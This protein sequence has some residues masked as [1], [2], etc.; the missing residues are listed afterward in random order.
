MGEHSKTDMLRIRVTEDERATLDGAAAAAGQPTGTWIRETALTA[1]AEQ[2]A[3]P[4]KK[5]SE[6]K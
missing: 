6:K 1:A 4:G 5:K 3:K 2:A